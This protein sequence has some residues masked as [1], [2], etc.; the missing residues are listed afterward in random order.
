MARPNNESKLKSWVD[1]HSD[2]MYSW[3]FHKT[4]NKE[5]SENLVQDTFLAAFNSIQK[6]E[7]KSEPKTWLF[8]I[9]HNK[10]AENFRK[11]YR[12]PVI[13]GSLGNEGFNVCNWDFFDKNDSC[14]KKEGPQSWLDAQ[15]HLLDD[16]SSVSGLNRRS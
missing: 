5:T 8:T 14:L 3:A 13:T 11:V 1:L 12:N 15:I 16:C 6:F 2:K 7:G 9:L 10:I 4:N